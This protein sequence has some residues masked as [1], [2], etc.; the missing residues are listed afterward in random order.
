[1][2]ALALWIATVGMGAPPNP[3]PLGGAAPYV[4]D[5]ILIG[6]RPDAPP[7]R[8]QAILRDLGADPGHRFRH[9]PAARH[10]IAIPVAKAIGRYRDDPAVRFI[11]PDYI[12]HA[13]AVPNDPSFAI[14]W[15]LRNTGQNHGVP[16]ADIHVTDAWDQVTGSSQVIVAIL[17]TGMDMTHPDL[18][19]NLYTNPGEIPG[20]LVDDDGDGYVDD[21]HGF[22]FA[23]FDGDPTDDNGHG[24]HVSGIIGAVGNNGL[25]ISGVAWR[26]QLLPVKFMDATGA[27]TTGDAIDGIEYAVE[28]GATIINASWGGGG[29][30]Q[31]LHDAI[32]E[33]NE[34]GV[35]FVAASGNDGVDNDVYANWPS[36]FDLPNVI[37]VASTNRV[38]GRSEFSN[39]GATTVD[40]GAPGGDI[41]STLRGGGY[42][43]MSGTSMAAPHVSG[44]LALL[45]T[46]FPAMPAATMKQVL[47]AATDRIPS[48]EGIT[49]TGGRLD[50][51]RMMAGVDS[52]GPAAIGDVALR[53]ASSDRV[54]IGFTATGDDG[55][56]G[57]ATRYDIRYATTPLDPSTFT[58]ATPVSG[59]P[60]PQPSGSQETIDVRGL[61]P[62]TRYYL[63]TVA[64]DEFGNR[65]PISNVLSFTTTA[66]PVID[67]TPGSLAATLKTGASATL[68]LSIRNTGEGALD[69]TAAAAGS[70]A[71]PPA[72]SWLSVAPPSGS[73]G[74]GATVA[75]T[76]TL[77]AAGLRGGD[78]RGYV[79]L[80]TNDP[81]EP[82]FDVPVTLHGISAPDIDVFPN[83]IAFGPVV[84]G[85][86]A[87]QGIL[88]QNVGYDDLHVTGVSVDNPQFSVDPTPFTLVPG[89]L[90][91]VP[92]SVTPA[93]P[94][95]VRGTLTIVSDDPDES[96]LRIAMG[97]TGQVPPVASLAPGRVADTL[98]TGESATIQL[99]V[100]N[101]GG[102]SLSWAAHARAARTLDTD[103]L[104]L[105][106]IATSVA[107][108]GG[109]TLATAPPA[110]RIESVAGTSDDANA[111]PPAD[112]SDL[113]V[114]FDTIHGGSAS[115]WSALIGALS[116]RGV[117][118]KANDL[119]VRA[120]VLS[121]AD[122]YWLTD[123][124]GPWADDGIQA[125]AQW[126]NQGGAVLL[127]GQA[128]TAL[129]IFNAILAATGVPAHF[130][131]ATG[132]VGPT[133]RLLPHEITR[134]ATS[135]NLPGSAAR[136]V[137][138]GSGAYDVLDDA[139]GAPALVAAFVGRGRVLAATGRL[140]ED[141]SAIFADN[142]RIASQA[143]DW[144][145]GASWLSA[146]PVY[147][148]TTAGGTTTLTTRL[149]ARRLTG[150]AYHGLVTFGSNDPAHPSLLVP[151]D[152]DVVAAPD[153]AVSADSVEF[154]PVFVGATVRDTIFVSNEGVLP[155][156][157]ASVT[158]TGPEF[159]VTPPSFTV[160]PGE[161][162]A[163]L[164]SYAPAAVAT[165]AASLVVRSDDPDRPEWTIPLAGLGLAPPEAMAGPPSFD[166]SLPT[167]TTVAR[168]LTVGNRAGSDLVY[169][170]RFEEAAPPPVPSAIDTAGPGAEPAL[171]RDWS[172][173][174]RSPLYGAARAELPG[175]V[176]AGGPTTLSAS[177]SLPLVLADPPGDGG[178]VDA[179]EL[180]ASARNGVLDVAIR[181]AADILPLNFYGYVSLDVDQ[182]VNTGRDPSFG[183]PRQDIG[184]EYEVGLFS[185]G[186]GFVDLFDARTG[187]YLG[188]VPVDVATREIRFR[189]PLATLGDDD[190]RMNV[191]A[192]LGNGV[193][194]T[195]WIPDRGHGV[196]GGRW[197][198]AWPDRGTV[199]AGDQQTVTLTIDGRGLPAGSYAGNVV[200]ETNDPA[201]PS[202]SMPAT[203]RV[204]DAASFSVPTQPI[205][206][207]DVFLGGTK[208]AD[209]LVTNAGT[210][211]LHAAASVTPAGEFAASPESLTV[212]AGGEGT[213]R[214]SFTPSAA[215]DRGAT[216]TITHDAPQPSATIGL[217]GIGVP[218]PVV[219]LDPPALAAGLDVGTASS[220]T[221]TIANDGGS[222]LGFA[223][224]AENGAASVPVSEAQTFDRDAEDPRSS[225]PVIL[226]RGGPDEFGTR[227]ID[228]DQRGGPVFDWVEIKD[229]GTPVALSELDETTDPLPIG[230][231]FPFYGKTF[232]TLRVCTHG[233]IS[234]TSGS[235]AFQNQPLPADE[236]P[237]NLI[238]P[239][240]DDLNFA[241]ARRAYVWNDG[242][243]LI[244]EY[245]HVPRRVTGGP[246]TFEAILYPSGAIVFQYLQM[247]APLNSATIGLQNAN[248]TDG[249]TVA[250]NA[251]Y[252]H[253]RM[254]IR[255][256]AAPRWLAVGP[257]EGNV[258]AG[259]SVPITV[260]TDAR[261]IF[262][263][264]YEGTI[265]VTS[266]DPAHP[267]SNATVTL[268]VTGIPDLAA[269]PLA[270]AF[271][272]TYLGQSATDTLHVTDAG[273]DRLH[274]RALVAPGG[275][276]TASPDTL[277]LAPLQG[278]PIYVRY[279][280]TAPGDRTATVTLVS[281]DPDG[282]VVIPITARAIAPPRITVSPESLAVAVASGGT[283]ARPLVV[284]NAGGSDLTWSASRADTLGTWLTVPAASGTLAPGASATVPL[285]IDG[286]GLADGAH[287]SAVLV[288][289]D[290]P[291]RPTTV[292]PVR[293][294]VGTV[295]VAA[296]VTP[297]A[298][299]RGSRGLPVNARV[300]LPAELDPSAVVASSVVL[301]GPATDALSTQ[302]V[303]V[304]VD[305]TPRD[306]GLDLTFDRATVVALLPDGDRVPLSI[307]GEIAGVTLFAARDTVRVMSRPYAAPGVELADG[308]IP[309]VS[310][311][312]PNAPNPFNPS[313]S[314][315]FDVAG[316]GGRATIRVFAANGRLVRTL[317]AADLP[318]GRF[319]TRWDG[320]D[321]AGR[322]AASG[323]YFCRL[324]LAGGA[325]GSFRE[326]RRM[327]L[328]R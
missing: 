69:F 154:G 320:K 303:A 315:R 231:A 235:T 318:A 321:G 302:S 100:R 284:T 179:T 198:G 181:T 103:S 47:L 162:R 145:G 141:A 49:V 310:A 85:E 262:G 185:L 130:V 313:T 66:P 168:L 26:V 113:R 24:T 127:N 128:A 278:A 121:T 308:S 15:S 306:G 48:L 314:I 98:R 132:T 260:A 281:D 227:W 285:T 305:V 172:S 210:L 319:L 12:V 144:L 123:A 225:G 242:T 304:A 25:G 1:M 291:F 59:V 160:A 17:D 38:D 274:V 46:R 223:V 228:S 289:S 155:L 316:G 31:A 226:G 142:Q 87:T 53:F 263:G 148:V 125:L 106:T 211:P 317:V 220:Q 279:A 108:E 246:Y 247:G 72:P 200:V 64:S 282:P 116:S 45:R 288:T 28:H 234:F 21:V 96:P 138:D 3:S 91:E 297:S 216:V 122:V 178:V 43:L 221:L 143:F 326:S 126:V 277:D 120:D 80:K 214:F 22:D 36:S 256:W 324:D 209:L 244:V 206:F 60:R 39:Y 135:A 232:T 86:T 261:G 296:R 42:G 82:V 6:F 166:A 257:P 254:A 4:P 219:R 294:H 295:E 199:A 68:T 167:G 286:A 34:E 212:P 78:Y 137:V 9:V 312:F 111:A 188:S 222:A 149:D 50:V 283:A 239:F 224:A 44:A 13:T 102:S 124:T 71:T 10:K 208:S 183:N 5:E 292:V 258:P 79:H 298:L 88:V 51:A 139:S 8:V 238:A 171:E 213:F 311:L 269:S 240:W 57:T 2:A 156:E 184:A 186:F 152:L 74:S 105:D 20:N 134:G 233:W 229:V 182:N 307:R 19:G 187:G 41:V 83:P 7:G 193:A 163:V 201:I 293:L 151:I 89:D 322:D 248:R 323:V 16:G 161:A 177:D 40:L 84:A 217:A 52:V 309:V 204:A 252:V 129:P 77:S 164:V 153:I 115:P 165:A 276:F 136:L 131:P 264:D 250:F 270:L 191:S 280:P 173:L 249:L 99:T 230:F 118:F 62:S 14:Q 215:G 114:L 92:L 11:E 265:R 176:A 32:A 194:P 90:W 245:D 273:T 169:T 327:L 241:Q 93:A 56:T 95:T 271:A 147:G 259:G 190:G 275:E 299:Q 268:H 112:L 94:G 255:F 58:A 119:P 97:A 65:S 205:G 63:A 218:A 159:T 170:V 27:G 251:D 75:V 29:Y 117:V 197:L 35:L 207:G 109:D 33:A 107:L 70:S 150:G 202:L 203:L 67:V 180:R 174:V 272:P 54:T 253:D 195:D 267:V 325:G 140:I 55:T 290:D 101:D 110:L 61:L 175:A 266:N 104:G 81:S 133:T 18:A 30:S 301:A 158:A 76:V 157:V 192:V 146:T 287:L 196:I 243:R 37:S 237:E 300:V 73:A 328:L 236:T 23:N 189:V